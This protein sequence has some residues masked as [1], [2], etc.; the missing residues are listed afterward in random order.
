MMKRDWLK[1]VVPVITL[2]YCHLLTSLE[3]AVWH[4]F[5]LHAKIEVTISQ[6]RVWSP[7]NVTYGIF[8]TN[9][10]AISLTAS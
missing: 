4:R 1:M 3:S 8:L 10:S 5:G 7:A 6:G 9:Q 2:Q